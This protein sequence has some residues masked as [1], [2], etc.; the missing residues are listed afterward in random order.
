[1][2]ASTIS[3]TLPVMAVPDTEIVI[4]SSVVD[5]GSEGDISVVV[6]SL[7]FTSFRSQLYLCYQ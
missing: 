7:S 4:G 1:M 3:L 2:L 6:I 5:R